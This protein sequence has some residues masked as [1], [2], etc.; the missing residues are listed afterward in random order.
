MQPTTDAIFAALRTCRTPEIPVDFGDPGLSRRGSPAQRA[1]LASAAERSPER[2]TDCPRL[3]DIVGPV[4]R[5]LL[6][7]ATASGKIACGPI[8]YPGFTSEE[9]RSRYQPAA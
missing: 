3:R 5:A 2:K 8:W 1:G 9:G 7:L 4:R 6:M